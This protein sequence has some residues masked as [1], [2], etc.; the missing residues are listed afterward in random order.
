MPKDL[1]C[2]KHK[3][4]LSLGE[5]RISFAN[6]FH[7]VRIGICPKCT[8]LYINQQL[9]SCSNIT[10]S[11]QKYEYLPEFS[12]INALPT[13]KAAVNSTIQEKAP[14][15]MD[16]IEHFFLEAEKDT[17]MQEEVEQLKTSKEALQKQ[18]DAEHRKR[19]ETENQYSTSLQGL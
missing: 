2:P 1:L 16:D 17:L 10:I 4:P 15:R 5:R 8:T 14:Q 7:D 19:I 9:M 12:R 13:K 3:I 11:G 6:S 18:F